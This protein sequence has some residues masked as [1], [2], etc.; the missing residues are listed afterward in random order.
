METVLID[1]FV[2]SNT[3][4]TGELWQLI[5]KAPDIARTVQPGQ[6]VHIL[7][8]NNSRHVLRRPLSVHA[9][10]YDET[11]EPDSL[12]FL[13]QVVGEGTS[14]LTTID[15]GSTLNILGPLGQGWRVPQDAR[16]ILLVG[17]GVGWAPLAMLAEDYLQ[18]GYVI[19][20]LIGAR[21][22]DYL[23]ALENNRPLVGAYSPER[24]FLHLATDDGSLGFHG[25]NT[26]LLDDLLGANS[27]DYIA[28]CGPEPMQKI[29][30]AQAAK[31]KIPCEVSLERRMGCGIGACLSCAV[32][33]TG[34]VKRSCIDGP[35]FDAREVLW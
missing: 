2:C 32:K 24:C 34:G 23:N 31:R 19:H 10:F 8:G 33:T 3:R 12:S 26:E 15:E 7:L 29:V 20:L 27:I 6:F 25:F 11:G 35:V 28:T 1:A 21:N 30:A 17:G 9:V 5:V 13:Y 18:R 14:Y 22:A 16:S 4:L